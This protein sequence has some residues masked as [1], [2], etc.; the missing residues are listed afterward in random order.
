[1]HLSFDLLLCKSL[2]KDSGILSLRG[3]SFQFV[4]PSEMTPEEQ[5]IVSS[6]AT[7]FVS[8]HGANFANMVWMNP[9]ATALE[10]VSKS[11]KKLH[12]EV[13]A[14]DY[15]TF[16]MKYVNGNSSSAGGLCLILIP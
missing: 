15:N 12:Y 2:H 10:I 6:R 1:M 4:N 11:Y 14:A 9:R 7:L 16:Y 3:Y 5:I 13:V 8:V